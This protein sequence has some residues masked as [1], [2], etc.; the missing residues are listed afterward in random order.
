MGKPDLKTKTRLAIGELLDRVL[1]SVAPRHPATPSR[2]LDLSELEE[3]ILLSA[4]PMLA[5]AEMA[6]PA[7]A[8]AMAK[9]ATATPEEKAAGMKPWMDWK[10][11]MGN[12]VLDFGSPLMGAV[13]LNHDGSDSHNQS[14]VTGYS[15]IEANDMDDAKSMLKSHPHL[16]WTPDCAIEVFE[17]MNMG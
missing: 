9:M 17:C 10:E 15:L 13:H 6:E 1:G 14:A 2:A 3:R 5:V 16:Q 7:P 12:R 11:K 4:S 8:E